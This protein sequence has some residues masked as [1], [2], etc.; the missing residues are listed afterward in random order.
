M[1]TPYPEV[2]GPIRVPVGNFIDEIVFLAV[3]DSLGNE[4]SG[5]DVISI[6]QLDQVE[7]A[8]VNGLHIGVIAKVVVSLLISIFKKV[9]AAPLPGIRITP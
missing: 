7:V 3:L 5:L 1:L 6:I 8:I 9:Q 4:K 2:A